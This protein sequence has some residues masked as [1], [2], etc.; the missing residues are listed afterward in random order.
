MSSNGMTPQFQL[1][2]VSQNDPGCSAGSQLSVIVH[3]P[4]GG[5]L[6]PQSFPVNEAVALP[7][8]PPPTPPPSPTWWIDLAAGIENASYTLVISGPNGANPTTITVNGSDMPQWVSR[9]EREK[10]N[11]IYKEGSCG[12]FGFAQ[13]SDKKDQPRTWIYTVTAGVDN[14]KIHPPQ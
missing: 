1:T 13:L 12:I 6:L 2:V 4:R 14:P 10:T 11:Q 5:S 8:P 7:V 9:N 3:P